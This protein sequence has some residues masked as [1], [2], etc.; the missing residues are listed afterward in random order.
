[1]SVSPAGTTEREPTFCLVSET[2][3]V[4]ESL[5]HDI[6][7]AVSRFGT[8]REALVPVLR[9]LKSKRGNI[10]RAAIHAVSSAL[11][12]D[13]AKVHRVASFYTLLESMPRRLPL[14]S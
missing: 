10:S 14:A 8:G 5:G 3:V 4:D 7:D 11:E 9:C 1:M 12:V 13:Y 2:P 6:E